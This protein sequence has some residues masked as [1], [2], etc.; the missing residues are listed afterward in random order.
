MAVE[1]TV[2][3][4]E[5]PT[6]CDGSQG[7]ATHH[8][9]Q[10]AAVSVP[11]GRSAG[12]WELFNQRDTIHGSEAYALISI[13]SG[14]V[15][16][17]HALHFGLVHCARSEIGELN[18]S[19]RTVREDRGPRFVGSLLVFHV[20]G[21]AAASPI[22]SGGV[23]GHVISSDCLGPI[24]VGATARNVGEG[25][26]R[27]EV[28]LG[29]GDITQGT[30]IGCGT[31]GASNTLPKEINEL[32]TGICSVFNAHEQIT[33]TIGVRSVE[34]DGERTAFAFGHNVEKT[35]VNDSSTGCGLKSTH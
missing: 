26:L 2:R 19:C 20:V 22:D 23:G 31:A 21:A 35:L 14:I 16:H 24:A 17:A 3:S 4:A 7:G 15:E 29:K 10:Q 11:I 34:L 6:A 13:Q 1:H 32:V 9:A 33:A 25:G 5:I 28:T 27:D 8:I 30:S 18:R 12:G